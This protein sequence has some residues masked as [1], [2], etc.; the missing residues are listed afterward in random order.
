M[1]IVIYLS[2]IKE[3]YMRK[4]DRAVLTLKNDLIVCN[5]G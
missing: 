1:D 2:F 3:V 5:M 4:Q